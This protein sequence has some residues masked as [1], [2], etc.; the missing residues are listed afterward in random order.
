MLN[1]LF[2]HAIGK[3]KFGGGEKWVL[4]AATGLRNEGFN[5]TV[6]GRPGSLLLKRAAGEGL[7]TLPFNIISDISIF[8]SFRIAS[9]IRKHNIDVVITRDRDLGVIGLAVRLAVSRLFPFPGSGNSGGKQDKPLVFVRHGLALRKS[10]KKHSFLMK[11]FADGLITNTSTIKDLYVS[12]GVAGKDFIKVI[13]N[14]TTP[15]EESPAFDFGKK[16]PGKR[17]ILSAGRLAGQKGFFHLVDA[18]ALL[19]KEYKNIMFLVF[20]KGRLLA[21]LKRYA[22]SKGVSDIVIFEGFVEETAPYLK[23]CD[24]FVLPSLYEGMPNAAMEAMGYAKP[25]VLTRV[26][27]AEELVAPGGD[28][29]LVPPADPLA[30]AEAIK[31]L[32]EDKRLCER[33]GEQ[34]RK[35]ILTNFTREKM[36]SSLREYIEAGMKAK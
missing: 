34:A 10:F 15:D 24:L 27:G 3:S 13:H 4:S 16:Y 11:R 33:L 9:F 22:Q 21:R 5:V 20:G 2:V 29:L 8:H 32:L 26:D 31:L 6:G 17:I 28:G 7:E 19:A 25:V 36:I 18:A 1:I 14:G 35:K 12:K 23:G 30:L